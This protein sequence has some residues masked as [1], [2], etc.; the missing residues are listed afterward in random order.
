MRGVATTVEKPDGR[1]RVGIYPPEADLVQP[2][3]GA[4]GRAVIFLELCGTS[5][6]RLIASG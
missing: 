1:S 2:R 5:A 3:D 4:D 6:P